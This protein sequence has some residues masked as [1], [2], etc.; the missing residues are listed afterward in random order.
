M[1]THIRG[2]WRSEPLISDYTHSRELAS[3]KFPGAGVARLQTCLAKERA[4]GSADP[5]TQISD[6]EI[7]D[8]PVNEELSDWAHPDQR[9]PNTHKRIRD[10]W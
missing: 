3:P 7:S 2:S 4:R 5:A 6:D 9:A 1:M 10:I 8:A